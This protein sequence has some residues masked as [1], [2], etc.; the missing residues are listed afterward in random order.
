VGCFDVVVV[1]AVDLGVLLAE[2]VADVLDAETI[3]VELD[4]AADSALCTGYTTPTGAMI[5]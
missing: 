1:T 2:L 3:F 4:A 5:T